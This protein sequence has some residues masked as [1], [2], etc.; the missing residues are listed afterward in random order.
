MALAIPVHTFCAAFRACHGAKP[1]GHNPKGRVHPGFEPFLP[2][3][4][5]LTHLSPQR[6]P[7]YRVLPRG[8]PA[9]WPVTLG[10]D[11]LL[12]SG[13]TVGAGDTGRSND[14]GYVLRSGVAEAFGLNA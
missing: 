8:R 3:L 11:G 10:A 7:L 4:P 9:P 12:R 6:V 1:F 13:D 5:S 2:D 14:P